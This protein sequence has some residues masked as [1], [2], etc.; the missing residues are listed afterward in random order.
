MPTKASVKHCPECGHI[1]ATRERTDVVPPV[2]TFCPR[3]GSGAATVLLR[4][5][6]LT[7][8]VSLARTMRRDGALEPAELAPAAAA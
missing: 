2:V 1:F 8:A 3:C 5:P 4:S 6:T 7:E